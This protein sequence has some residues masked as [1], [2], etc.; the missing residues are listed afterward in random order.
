[1]INDFKSVPKKKVPKYEVNIEELRKELRLYNLDNI[2]DEVDVVMNNVKR[3]EK[4]V[5]KKDIYFLRKIAKTVIREDKLANKNLVFNN[6]TINAK[7]KK[8]Y[9]RRAKTNNKDENENENLERQQRIEMINDGPDFF[10]ENYLS[11]LIK[12]YKTMKIK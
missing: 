8:I 7:L 4:L 10:S 6:N 1:M 5:K 2:V 11:N 3:M 9:E 12:R